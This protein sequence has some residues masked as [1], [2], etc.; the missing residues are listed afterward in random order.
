MLITLS[1]LFFVFSCFYF[2]INFLKTQKSDAS[3]ASDASDASHERELMEFEA[4]LVGIM[5]L[6]F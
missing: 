6:T 5:P 1:P 3:N 4:E 2:N